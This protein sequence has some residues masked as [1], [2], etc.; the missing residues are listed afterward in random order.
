MYKIGSSASAGW[1]W[2]NENQDIVFSEIPLKQGLQKLK[3]YISD[4]NGNVVEKIIEV[5]GL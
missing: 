2:F 1:K 5:W 3:L 4:I